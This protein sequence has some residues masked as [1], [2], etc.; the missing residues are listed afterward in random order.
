MRE[1]PDELC[2]LT[3]RC[4]EN[5]AWQDWG[6]VCR[7]CIGPVL[8]APQTALQAGHVAPRSARGSED[9]AR[10]VIQ[11]GRFL[12]STHYRLFLEPPESAF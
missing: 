3:L 8:S 5:Q 4:R 9:E 6:P 7:G 10:R 11:E 12:G 2:N 1:T